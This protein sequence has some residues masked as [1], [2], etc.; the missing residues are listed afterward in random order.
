[1]DR[2]ERIVKMRPGE[3]QVHMKKLVKARESIDFVK[4]PQK[5][6]MLYERK[7]DWAIAGGIAEGIAGPAAGVTVAQNIIRE[8]QA[9]DQRNKNITRTLAL[10][11]LTC[12]PKDEERV[13]VLE[14]N[15][16]QKVTVEELKNQICVNLAAL[17]ETLFQKLYFPS[18][19]CFRN[20]E[21][22]SIIVSIR[23]RI[24]ENVKLE[25]KIHGSLR[26]KVYTPDEKYVGCAYINLPYYF[27]SGDDLS[28]IITSQSMYSSIYLKDIKK[29]EIVM[30]YVDL[31]ELVP[32]ESR[33]AT[34]NLRTEQ[35]HNRI[36]AEHEAEFL[37]EEK[38]AADDRIRLVK[39]YRY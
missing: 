20:D 27:S 33:R 8:N 17:P 32:K 28:G 38:Q 18:K 13:K 21:T 25:F 37:K 7:R 26:A 36:V 39:E 11:S 14:N 29:F 1:M 2:L 19:K 31:W 16:P 35:L 6:A 24:R 34:N 30:D 3:I 23:C 4:N 15:I 9:I 22:G 12:L 5:H 10:Y